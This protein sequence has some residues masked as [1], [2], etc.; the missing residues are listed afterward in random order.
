MSHSLFGDGVKFFNIAHRGFSAKA[1][2]N[3]MAAFEMAIGAGANMLELDVMLT[4]DGHVIV[5]HDHHLNRTTDG[6]GSVRKK[7]LAEIRSLDAGSWFGDKYRGERVPLL[8]EVLEVAKGRVRLDIELKPRRRGSIGGLVDACVKIVERHR[9]SDDVVLSSF[10]MKVLKYLHRKEPGFRF[11][12]LYTSRLS[13]ARRSFAGRYGAQTVVLNHIFL[14]ST[15]VHRFH[16]LGIGVFVY[17][18]NGRRRIE[19]MVRMGVD[20]VISDDPSEVSA[21]IKRVSGQSSPKI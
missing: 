13:A 14:K 18:V 3:T 16:D 17:T 5:F 4:R 12:P 11:G 21:V 20:G 19:K 1:P 9:M 2:E 8:D 15:T 6:R 10:N 7:R